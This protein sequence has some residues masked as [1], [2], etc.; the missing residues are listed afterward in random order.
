MYAYKNDLI[1]IHAM[2]S[3]F[4][5]NRIID[6]K[7]LSKMDAVI[8]KSEEEQFKTLNCSL[9]LDVQRTLFGAVRNINTTLKCMKQK[10][11]TAAERHENPTTAENALE[12]M[13]SLNNLVYSINCYDSGCRNCNL[14]EIDSFSRILYRKAKSFGFSEDIEIQLKEAGVTSSQIESFIA[15]FDNN[16]AQELDI[17]EEVKVNS[18]DNS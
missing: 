12:L 15:S 5:K 9:P 11:S 13:E 1:V 7:Q 14:G 18:E 6:S 17:E 2:L 10:L 16:I 3:N 4:V 8:N